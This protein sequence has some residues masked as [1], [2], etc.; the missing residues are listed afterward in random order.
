[1]LPPFAHA[2]WLEVVP[3]YNPFKYNSFPV[4]AARQSSQLT[5]ALQ[6][7]LARLSSSGRLAALPPLLTFQSMVDHTV[8]TP[9]VVRTLYGQLPDNGSELVLFDINRRATA[10]TLLRASADTAVERIVVP[11]PRRYAMA[12][13][14]NAPGDDP[15]RVVERR[16]PAGSLDET[17]HALDGLRYPRELFSLSH[18]ALPFPP[19]DGLYGAQPAPGDDAGVQLGTLSARGET[20][21]LI[22]GLDAI[23]RASFN[24]FFALLQQRIDAA[25]AAPPR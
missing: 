20:G 21:V 19:H 18:I 5:R 15:E 4:N 13:V 12:L 2:A 14:T 3:E 1:V 6:S 16:T 22:V 10:S 23:S 11:P 25:I 9:A 17:V 8:S 7:Q 24:P